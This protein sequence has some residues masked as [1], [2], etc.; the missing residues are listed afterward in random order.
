MLKRT[1]QTGDTL[2]E[3]ILACSILALV[4]VGA[5]S[6]MQRGAASA[7][8]ALE[9][10]QVRLELD[11]QAEYLYYFRDLYVKAIKDQVTPAAGSPES[12]W[13]VITGYSEIGAVPLS[14]CPTTGGFYFTGPTTMPGT[15]LT[16]TDGLPEPGKGLWIV[17]QDANGFG[18][19]NHKYR[20]FYIVA[21]WTTTTGQPQ[22]MSS[23]VRMYEPE[24]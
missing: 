22:S 13:P 24:P 19:M 11:R 7:Y 23:V 20:D 12:V 17:R 10:S 2:I 3:V 16:T 4:T 15:V 18:S 1:R 21:C 8:N 6:I 9:R 14:T 5:F